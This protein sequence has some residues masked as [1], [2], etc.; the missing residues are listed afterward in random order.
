MDIR[1]RSQSGEASA[2][3]VASLSVVQR[4]LD[5]TRQALVSTQIQ[6]EAKEHA[7]A[8]AK[9]H[10]ATLECKLSI[11]TNGTVTPNKGSHIS[12]TSADV[13]SRAFNA[14]DVNG[15]GVITR[16]EFENDKLS[17]AFAGAFDAI[18]AN[19]DG[20]LSREEFRTGYAL[21]TSNS[22]DAIAEREKIDRAVA[23][24][25]IRAIKEAALALYE[26][27]L[28]E[29]LLGPPELSR[30]ASRGRRAPP[31]RIGSTEPYKLYGPIPPSFERE[32]IERLVAARVEA[33]KGREYGKADKLQ[34]KLDTM[35][36]KLDDRWRTW[37]VPVWLE[38]V[39]GPFERTHREAAEYRHKHPREARV[40][41]PEVRSCQASK[42]SGLER[43]G[44]R[45][46]THR[47]HW[48]RRK[49]TADTAQ[50]Q[51]VAADVLEALKK[52]P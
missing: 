32:Q 48:R 35:G 13:I 24:E 37:S 51:K 1:G 47:A 7:E 18:D 45:G 40:A 21:L 23:A 49:R 36:V 52:G 41:D 15:D 9:E 28:M 12:K 17:R 44:H 2:S 33:K 3:Q 22:T 34:R 46:K 26:A 6:L 38:V 30:A 43:I 50:Q 39:R 25:R 14:L 5:E 4:E 8:V 11:L 19:E 10:I 16:E 27:Q 20:V 29:S 31:P 42:S